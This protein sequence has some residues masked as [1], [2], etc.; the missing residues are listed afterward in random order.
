[1]THF[2][3]AREGPTNA[4]WTSLVCGTLPPAALAKRLDT[5]PRIGTALVQ[6]RQVLSPMVL[7]RFVTRH[8]TL[9]LAVRIHVALPRC[10]ANAMR[11]RVPL[12]KH[13]VPVPTGS[14]I[15]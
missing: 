11:R 10:H 8:S 6:D 2:Q 1:M 5:A 9:A 3:H 14:A 12:D 13:L 15:S 4:R 7:A